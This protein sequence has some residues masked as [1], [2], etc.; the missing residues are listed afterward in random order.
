MRKEHISVPYGAILK[1][2]EGDYILAGSPITK[3]PS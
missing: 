3:G 2:K 1:V